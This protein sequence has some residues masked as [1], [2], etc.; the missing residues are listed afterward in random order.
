MRRGQRVELWDMAAGEQVRLLADDF[1]GYAVK[2]Q[3]GTVYLLYP[4][5]IQVLEGVLSSVHR[6]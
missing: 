1:R 4:R 3:E 6:S 2:V 5:E